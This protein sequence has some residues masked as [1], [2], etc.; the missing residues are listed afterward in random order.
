MK[1]SWVKG[2]KNKYKIFSNGT[3]VSYVQNKQAGRKLT[4]RKSGSGY[5]MVTVFGKQ[6]YVHK[7]VAEHFVLNQD[8]KKNPIILFK[9]GNLNNVD[10]SNLFCGNTSVRGE[11]RSQN[12]KELLKKQ[13]M[14]NKHLSG[15]DILEI[16]K[17]LKYNKESKKNISEKFK[18]HRITLYRILKTDAYKE[19]ILSV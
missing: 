15:T 14:F 16:A 4:P 5:L 9:D 19:V 12:E 13:K 2:T 7:L 10:Y 1:S 6:T 17:L 3:I 8:K 18:I 11:K